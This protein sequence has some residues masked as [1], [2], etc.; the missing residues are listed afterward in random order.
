MTARAGQLQPI[1]YI[2]VSTSRSRSSMETAE[3]RPAATALRP[4]YAVIVITAARSTAIAI[5][6]GHLHR[7]G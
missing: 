3:P 4:F 7:A 1:R 5:A 2:V 6:A